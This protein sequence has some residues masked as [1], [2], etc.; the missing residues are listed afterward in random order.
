MVL[1]SQAILAWTSLAPGS[2][3]KNAQDMKLVVYRP[4]MNHI[5]TFPDN[6]VF[7]MLEAQFGAGKQATTFHGKLLW[8]RFSSYGPS[9]GSLKTKA[10]GRTCYERASR[11]QKCYDHNLIFS[12]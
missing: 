11:D 2:D 6:G 8:K 1:L 5:K 3:C 7:Y 9:S 12:N 10:R 4:R